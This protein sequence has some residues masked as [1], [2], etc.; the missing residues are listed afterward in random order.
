MQAVDHKQRDGK[1]QYNVQI[2]VCS[3]HVATRTY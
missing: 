1:R 2:S 3:S